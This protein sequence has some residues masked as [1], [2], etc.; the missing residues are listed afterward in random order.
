MDLNN[1]H[2]HMD[3]N[4]YKNFKEGKNKFMKEWSIAGY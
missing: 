1:R 3:L 2:F 4:Q